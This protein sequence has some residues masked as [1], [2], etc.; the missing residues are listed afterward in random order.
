MKRNRGKSKK[1]VCIVKIGNN[2]D[3]T[4]KCVKYR[5]NDLSKFVSFI[6]KKFPEWSW[7]NVYLKE[8]GEQKMSFTKF[9]RPVGR[10][11]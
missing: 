5:L 8:T 9:N 4:A 11:G 2:Q 7:F 10:D 1:Y 3:K 6:D